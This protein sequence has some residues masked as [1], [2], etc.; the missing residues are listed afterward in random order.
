MSTAPRDSA[1]FAEAL[2]WQWE[3]IEVCIGTRIDRADPDLKPYLHLA[4]TTGPKRVCWNSAIAPHNFEGFFL[5]MGDMLVKSGDWRTAQ[6]LYRNATL[7]PD[8]SAWPYAQVLERRIVEAEANVAAFN[9]LP[10]T[11]NDASGQGEPPADVAAGDHRLMIDT[12][13]S[14]MGCHQSLRT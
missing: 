3:N 12:R 8:F 9:A 7:S 4:T 5:N 11:G 10:P 13:F 1:R 6:I 2:R 14:C